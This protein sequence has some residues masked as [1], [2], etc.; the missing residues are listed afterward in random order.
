MY[1]L[2]ILTGIASA[3]DDSS[4]AVGPDAG[5]APLE[6]P[7]CP[8]LSCPEVPPC[9]DHSADDALLA[10]LLRLLDSDSGADAADQLGALGDARVIP[11]LDHTARTRRIEVASA[12]CQALARYP[13]ALV[14]LA[15]MVSD[16]ALG[17]PVR[18]A[19]AQALGA[20]GSEPA[21]DS[22]VALM[23]EQLPR[24]LR[25][26][27]L[28]T[29]RTAYPH[30][31]DELEGEVARRGTGWLMVG[32]AGAL[33]YSL[34]SVGYFG[35]ADLEVLGAI[36]GGAAGGSLGYVAGRRWPIEAGDAAFLSST[37]L[38][39]TSSGVLLGCAAGDDGAC[40]VGGL[41]GEVA[42]FGTGALLMDR[43]PGTQGDTVEALVVS[44]A[45]GL[46]TGTGTSW[47]VERSMVPRQSQ[48][49]DDLEAYDRAWSEVDWGKVTRSTQIATGLGLAGGLAAGHYIAPRVELSGS[50]IGHMTLSG[51][52]G[53]FSGGLLAADESEGR[54]LFAGVG[55]GTLL[56][57]GLANP[58]ELGGDAVFTGYA[59]L[60]YGSMVGLGASMV[61]DNWIDLS[62]DTGEGLTKGVVWVTGT[63]GMGLGS[64]Q[65]WKNPNGI[66]FNDV[67][68]TGLATS[69]ATWQTTGWW[70]YADQPQETLGMNFLVPAA[71]GSAAA[72]GSPHIDIGVGDTLSATSLGLWG[73]YLGLAGSALA[74]A[75][76]DETLLAT[77]V[78]SDIGLGAGVLLMS[79]LVDASPVVVGLA[80]AG[81]VAG[82]TMGA[83]I[84]ALATGDQDP[85]LVAS[86]IGAGAGALG[87]GLAG[88]AI[89]RSDR[90]RHARLL[91]PKPR[92][93]L[94]G[95]WAIAPT[96]VTDGEIVG[97]GAG[98]QVTGW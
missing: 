50:D 54:S 84:V 34:A 9:P 93:R 18:Q 74:D 1:T 37:G 55:A 48:Y 69:W 98:L 21:A 97:Y 11:P 6:A 68:F 76:G 90:Q 5:G 19:A 53:G 4:T 49:G 32:G 23:D 64:Y 61:A 42:G 45:T 58:M 62:Q 89:E 91:L 29:V 63:A 38:V 85:I 73:T 71:I 20:M 36:T 79:P 3:Q 87:G 24:D 67:V 27:V 52:W 31:V 56:G 26:T 2:L 46:A 95:D 57:Y 94:P 83:V 33:G 8:E 16:D 17:V 78:V 7:A 72:I 60:G 92:L 25:E 66:R 82:A 22:L 75:D 41:L 28:S 30:R 80:D 70:N 96:T 47:L 44:G 51:V 35:Q 12:A 14:P 65:A 81:G 77:L 40:W 88:R 86:M 39:G 59:G 13:D 43:H 15:T 10:Q